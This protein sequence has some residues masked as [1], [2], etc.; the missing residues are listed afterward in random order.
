MHAFSTTEQ[1]ALHASPPP[2]HNA[3][4]A[5]SAASHRYLQRPRAS[6]FS[7]SHRDAFSHKAVGSVTLPISSAMI[8]QAVFQSLTQREET[9]SPRKSQIASTFASAAAQ[10][11]L[12]IVPSTAPKIVLHTEHLQLSQHVFGSKGHF[13]EIEHAP[14]STDKGSSGRG[15]NCAGGKR[16]RGLSAI[17]QTQL[18]ARV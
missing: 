10:P 11:D 5:E 17:A 12:G 3:L 1:A 16:G 8:G 9:G 4:Q 14:D 18:R 6:E 7:E 2:G 13:Q 15:A